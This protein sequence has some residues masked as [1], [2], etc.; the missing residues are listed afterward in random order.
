[1][2]QVTK[3]IE[4]TC[5]WLAD[6]QFPHASAQCVAVEPRDFC[7]PVLAAHFPM[8]L[9]KYPANT[10]LIFIISNMV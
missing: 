4:S 6:T 3:Q 5:L 10:D 2:A 1:M 8:G 9:L 7:S